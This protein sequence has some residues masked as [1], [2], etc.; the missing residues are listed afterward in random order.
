MSQTYSLSLLYKK[1]KPD[2]LASQGLTGI[3]TA[4]VVLIF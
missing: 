2:S 4:N 1:T 3:N